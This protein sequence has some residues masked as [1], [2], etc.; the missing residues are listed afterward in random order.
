V[1]IFFHFTHFQWLPGLQQILQSHK[2]RKSEI[3]ERKELG[4]GSV[5][6]AVMKTEICHRSV[7]V[8]SFEFKTTGTSDHFYLYKLFCNV[9]LV[10]KLMMEVKAPLL[11]DHDTEGSELL[12]LQAGG[13]S[14]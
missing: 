7:A 12:G 2:W 8:L 3:S 4:F 1:R 9:L 11:T 13:L 5:F 6:S 10:N 14:R